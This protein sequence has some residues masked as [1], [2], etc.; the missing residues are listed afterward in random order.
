VTA[1]FCN[2]TIQALADGAPNLRRS[3]NQRIGAAAEKYCLTKSS[4]RRIIAVSYQ[5]K[6][7]IERE[8]GV[9]PDK[10]IVI[11]HGVDVETFHPGHRARWRVLVRD[12]LGL[13]HNE[14]VALFVGADYHRKGLIPLLQAV[15]RVG[16]ALK[17]LA[18]GVKRDAT[19]AR[20]LED[21]GLASLVRFVSHCTDIAPLYAAADCFVLPTRYEP[22]SL[23]TL[24]A[25]AAGLP[26]VISRVAG[27]SELLKADR[28][29]F[30]LQ[31]AEDVDVLADRLGRLARDQ[32]L[33][34]TLGAEARKTAERHS[35]D[36]VANRTLAV[37]QD[38]LAC[39]DHRI[40]V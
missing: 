9:D 6:S 37:Y 32:A 8:Y 35:W 31:D 26:V 24:E 11:P 12:R 15:Q 16:P 30:I 39:S 20:I 25:M 10:T 13:G 18:V 34:A 29:C 5:V 4:T 21:N 40:A 7:E 17:I 2:Q 23:A 27:V 1:H 19:L 3:I 22:F 14:F 38:V 33:R 36:E 28:D